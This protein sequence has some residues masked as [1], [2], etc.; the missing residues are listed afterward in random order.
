MMPTITTYSK[1]APFYNAVTIVTNFYW[2]DSTKL[3]RQSETAHAIEQASTELHQSSNLEFLRRKRI[4]PFDREARF[5]DLRGVRWGN[6]GELRSNVVDDIEIA[7]GTIVVAQSEI[8]PYRVGVRCVHLKETCKGQEPVE[9]VVS[10]KA[11]Q[12]N[13][14]MSVSQRQSKSIPCFR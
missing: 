8:C 13:R 5:A 12:D 14:K 7:I 2:A 4:G 3:D 6:A 11:C 10:L 1:R 9:R